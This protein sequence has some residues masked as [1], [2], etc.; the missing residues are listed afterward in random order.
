M[1][2]VAKRRLAIAEVVVEENVESVVAEVVQDEVEPMSEARP[3][4]LRLL[5]ALLFASAE[6]LDEKTL[7]ARLPQGVDVKEA[8]KQ[9]QAEYAS[10]G[11]NLV[12]V[13]GK[14]A[15]RTANDLSWLLTKDSVVPRKLS[16]A[17][18]ETL[19]IVAYHQPVT[20]AEVEEIRGIS[21]A[22]VSGYSASAQ[23]SNF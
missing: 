14:W 18:I 16:R 1:P 22:K 7:G 5:E 8:L 9:L 23:S 10:R 19:A 15:F 21:A 3:E 13:A 17:A 4:E 6:P 20:R 11:V 2:S 12:R